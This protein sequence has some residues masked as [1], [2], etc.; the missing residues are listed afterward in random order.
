MKFRENILKLYLIADQGKENLLEKTESALKGGVTFV[1][2][3]MK[4][5]GSREFYEMALKMKTLCD[6]Y[7][8]PL[9]IN[10]RV[11]IAIAVDAAGVHIGQGDLPADVVR[12]ILGKEKIVGV[13]A[14]KE[15]EV[16]QA[17]RDGADYVGAGAFVSTGT[18][19]N[20]SLMTFDYFED[21]CSFSEIPVVGI[22]GVTED[23]AAKIINCGAAG[24]SVCAAILD[25]E[26]PEK[27]AN[28]FLKELQRV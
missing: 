5:A 24:V 8:I 25:K 6:S 28:I 15:E 27:A 13:S 14:K 20:S 19:P 22:G 23:L 21:L 11:D 9:V 18:K 17:I 1:Q 10:D 26:N 2:L 12:R 7:E 3:R 16:L 4:E